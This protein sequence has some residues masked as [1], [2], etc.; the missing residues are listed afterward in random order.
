MLPSRLSFLTQ[1]GSDLALA[2][3][4]KTRLGSRNKG[5][6]YGRSQK[7]DYSTFLVICKGLK[8]L[9]KSCVTILSKTVVHF[10]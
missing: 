8:F 7:V 5:N 2:F 10:C 9:D 6:R 4:L 1:F 3:D